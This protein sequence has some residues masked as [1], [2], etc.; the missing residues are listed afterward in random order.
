[1]TWNALDSVLTDGKGMGDFEQSADK[2]H[3]PFERIMLAVRCQ[4]EL[5]RG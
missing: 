4:N 5:L 3:Q 1:M 2:S